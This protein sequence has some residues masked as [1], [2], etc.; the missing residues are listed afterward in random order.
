MPTDWLAEAVSR[1]G[2]GLGV[3]A[4]FV[5][6][7]L[8][9]LTPCV[10]PMIPV[11]LAFFTQQARGA[12]RHTARL[13]LLYMAG[14]SLSY[15]V[16][17]AVASATGALFGSWLQSPIVLIW[18]AIAIIA[19]SLSMFGVYELRVPPAILQRLGRAG[20]GHWGAF[21]MGLGVGVVAAP[22]VGPFLV[23]L[24]LVIG[25]MADPAAGFV[26]FF[27]LGL[28]MGLPSVLLAVAAQ[29]LGQLPKAGEWL[30]WSK[31][32]LGVTLIGVAVWMVR[33][34]LPGPLLTGLVV[35]LCTAAGIYLGW[36][37]RSRSR[38]GR[39]RLVRRRLGAAL[40]AAGV[41]AA[42]PRPANGPAV[43]WQPYAAAALERAVRAHQPVVI[44]VYADWCLPCVELDRVSFRHPDV[45]QAMEGIV[46]LRID[47]TRQA[48][49]DAQALFQRYEVY[50]VPTVLL[51]DG[52]GVE[53]AALRVLGFVPPKELRRRLQ[54]IR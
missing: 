18:I 8:L 24:L 52:Q 40:I 50:G 5:G 27:V 19:L 51:F 29:R 16:L 1:H 37:E 12:S 26:L 54:L 10:Y 49:S 47:V 32:A 33:P 34:L 6:G 30:V 11:T 39:L 42:W 14:L 20:A 13:A 46:P 25:R 7:L 45:V 31:K 23:S 44:D 3:L 4:V 36:L 15:A 17:G 21:A 53:R 38:S 48:S 28:G 35:A 9:N 43:A 22:C 41:V 2:F